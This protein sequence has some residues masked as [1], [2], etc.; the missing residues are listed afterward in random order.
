MQEHQVFK[1]QVGDSFGVFWKKNKNKHITLF[2]LYKKI[3][4][5][6]F[7]FIVKNM[8]IL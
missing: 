8:Y 6:F 4:F 3:T 5:K 2:C 7:C 1:F